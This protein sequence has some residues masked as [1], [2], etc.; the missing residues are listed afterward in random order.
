MPGVVVL[1]LL[2]Y[3]FPNTS[4]NVLV[5]VGLSIS[6]LFIIG[7]V[8]NM[9]LPLLGISRPLTLMPLLLLLNIFTLSVS[10]LAYYLNRK[11]LREFPK[12]TVSIKQYFSTKTLALTLVPVLSILGTYLVNYHNVN[13]LL[14]VLI[15]I[16][17]IIFLSAIFNFIFTS[18]DYSF[19]IWIAAISLLLHRTLI[20]EYIMAFDVLGEMFVANTILNSGI[21]NIASIYYGAYGSALSVTILPIYY[22]LI[23]NLDLT[24]VYKIIFPFFLSLVPLGLYLIYRN[25]VNAKTAFASA[26]LF[27]VIEDF[28]VQIPYI[29]K[30]VIAQ[31]FLCLV[32]YLLLNK[33]RQNRLYL[34]FLMIF[35]AGLIVSHYGTALLVLLGL[36]FVFLCTQIFKRLAEFKS[37]H[38][39]T[40]TFK[41][42]FNY[43]S[44][45]IS[46]NYVLLYSILL[47]TWY[48]CISESVTFATTVKIGD[49][50]GDALFTSFLDPETSRGAFFFAKTYSSH[51][52]TLY[53]SLQYVIIGFTCLGLLSSFLNFRKNRFDSEY[54]FFALFWFLI[55]VSSICISYFAVMNPGRLFQLSMFFFAPLF[56][57]GF[58]SI[59]AIFG[60][61]T[62]TKYNIQHYLN[63]G[64]I[65]FMCVYL[66]LSSGFLHEILNEEPRSLSISQQTI[67]DEKDLQSTGFLHLN[68]LIISPQ[69][70]AGSVWLS[71]FRIIGYPIYLNK[72]YG[73]GLGPLVAYGHIDRSDISEILNER[74]ISPRSYVFLFGYNTEYNLVLETNEI[75]IISFS[76]IPTSI[77]SELAK[78]SNVYTNGQNYI[79]Y[80]A[81]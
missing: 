51:L 71:N 40:G 54:L 19:I 29:P 38:I 59:N 58:Q 69:D 20:S 70:V 13:I 33:E 43:L 30:Q 39:G 36:F 4:D 61:I 14:L 63:M 35:S 21:W 42:R 23:C 50:I 10:T 45:N 67:I 9:L 66:M 81:L 7:F 56:I 26:F 73:Q 60:K 2:R 75:G 5:V 53:K 79:D 37:T 3:R 16:L 74:Q 31:L 32:I 47:I 78:A 25:Y 12:P 80:N 64:I 15:V 77:E 65:L 55:C 28:F 22:N 24:W 11:D 48:T 72:G 44:K 68:T 8:A 57:L 1:N 18:K 62:N 52:Q 49:H 41:S 17:I 6:T 76:T 27:I 34:L 46:L